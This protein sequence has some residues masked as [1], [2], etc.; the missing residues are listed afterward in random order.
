VWESRPPSLDRTPKT[1]DEIARSDRTDQE[2]E[3][4]VASTNVDIRSL[5]IVIGG[6]VT[7]L[8][9]IIGSAGRLGMTGIYALTV[10]VSLS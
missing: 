7:E 1:N 3:L 10:R 6:G 2:I 9:L 4:R 5:D 8:D